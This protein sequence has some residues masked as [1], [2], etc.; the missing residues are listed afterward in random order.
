VAGE[1]RK[2]E[3]IYRK[4]EQTFTSFYDGTTFCGLR[5]GLAFKDVIRPDPMTRKCPRGMKA[6]STNTG[7]QETVCYSEEDIERG[8]CPINYLNFTNWNLKSSK[9]DHGLP[10]VTT[11]LSSG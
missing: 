11:K 4:P 9:N 3:K 2:C 8:L 10:I 6:C 7:L 5:G 1:S